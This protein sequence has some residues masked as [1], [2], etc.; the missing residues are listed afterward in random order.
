[1]YEFICNEPELMPVQA[2][3]GSAFDLKSA[4]D[5]Y[6]QPGQTLLI[7][8]GVKIKLKPGYCGLVLSRSGIALRNSVFLLNAPGLIDTDYAGELCAILHNLGS[9]AFCICR[10]DRIAQLL[11]IENKLTIGLTD[12]ARG[13][14]G[15]GST[16]IA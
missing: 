3:P 16:G 7:K 11:I 9:E 12:Y 13:E 15:F 6:L 2:T 1:M 14:N 10:C 4:D 5:Y 8:C